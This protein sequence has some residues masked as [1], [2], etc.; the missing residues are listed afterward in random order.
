VFAAIGE[1]WGGLD[2]LVHAIAFSDKG[3]LN[4]PLCRYDARDF[5]RTLDISCFSFTD[6]CRR[7]VPLMPRAAA[8]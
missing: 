8:C 3:E 1:R 2:F 5:L 6:L 4:R 7:A